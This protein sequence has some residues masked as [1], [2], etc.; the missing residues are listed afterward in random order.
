MFKVACTWPRVLAVL[1]KVVYE[2]MNSVSLC[3]V[4]FSFSGSKSEIH[5]IIMTAHWRNNAFSQIKTWWVLISKEGR[6]VTWPQHCQSQSGLSHQW[7]GKKP[8][9]RLHPTKN[10]YFSNILVHVLFHV[11]LYCNSHHW[12]KSQKSFGELAHVRKGHCTWCPPCE[13]LQVMA[14]PWV[15]WATSRPLC[16]PW[17]VLEGLPGSSHFPLSF[18]RW[19]FNEEYQMYCLKFLHTKFWRSTQFKFQLQILKF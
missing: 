7:Q 16:P 3:H 1:C 10:W 15:V 18:H 5:V 13:E 6:A 11:L 19:S 9:C 2:L 17:H 12:N 8:V 4:E 14:V